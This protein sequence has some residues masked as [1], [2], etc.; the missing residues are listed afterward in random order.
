MPVP[1]NN[2]SI[3]LIPGMQAEFSVNDFYCKHGTEKCQ[4]AD[5]TYE[6]KT[7]VNGFYVLDED[8]GTIESI[9]GG[10]KVLYTHK[11]FASNQIVFV[12]LTREIGTV[13]VISVPIHDH[14]SIVTGGPAYATYFADDENTENT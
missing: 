12:A 5:G 7:L 2:S 10:A 4:K 1:Q 8:V 3:Y 11:K 13:D 14:S 6:N 9:A